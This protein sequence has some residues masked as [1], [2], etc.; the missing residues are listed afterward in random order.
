V[1]FAAIFVNSML[2]CWSKI[3]SL[4]NQSVSQSSAKEKEPADWLTG[5]S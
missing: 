5:D 3:V 1:V 4:V 2:L